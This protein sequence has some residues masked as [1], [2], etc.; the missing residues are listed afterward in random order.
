[1]KDSR[2]DIAILVLNKKV[3][4]NERTRPI[5]LQTIV[6]ESKSTLIG[7]GWGKP[8]RGSPTSEDLKIVELERFP[9][10]E[11]TEKYDKFKQLNFTTEFCAVAKVEGKDICTVSK[12]KYLSTI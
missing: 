3:D 8:S 6:D 4:F 10:V 9:N 12:L 5:C 1:M 11:C 2:N 7:T